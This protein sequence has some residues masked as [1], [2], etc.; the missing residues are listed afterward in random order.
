MGLFYYGVM[1]PL[2]IPYNYIFIKI[3]LPC[4]PKTSIWKC[5]DTMNNQLKCHVI[6]ERQTFGINIV[7]HILLEDNLSLNTPLFISFA[8]FYSSFILHCF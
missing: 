8:L 3:Q 2:I 4:I 7:F 6:Q 5:N 1:H